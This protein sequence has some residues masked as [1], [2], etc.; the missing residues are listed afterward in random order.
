MTELLTSIGYDRWIIHVLLALPLIGMALVILSPK[1][2]ARV[3]ALVVALVEFVV[4]LGLWWA[5]DPSKTGLQFVTRVDCR[6][7]ATAARIAS[8]RTATR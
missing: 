1:E 5:F 8:T 6:I 3:V 4:S 2:W 7:V